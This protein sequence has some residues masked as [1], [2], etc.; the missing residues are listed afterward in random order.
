MAIPDMFIKLLKAGP[1]PCH[2]ND[3]EPHAD[4]PYM[5]GGR[6]LSLCWVSILFEWAVLLRA[7]GRG[8]VQYDE[9]TSHRRSW[10]VRMSRSARDRPAT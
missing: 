5:G 6:R 2:Q 1:P 8:V 3:T 4:P 9:H 7:Y 10:S